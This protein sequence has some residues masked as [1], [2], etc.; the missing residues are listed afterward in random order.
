MKSVI[1]LACH[2]GI[3]GSS[4]VGTANLGVAQSGSASALGAEGRRFESYHRDHSRRVAQLGEHYGDNVEV[5][6]S[7]PSPPTIYIIIKLRNFDAV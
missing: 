5:D 6:G 4:P 3:T 1:T 7:N 2:A